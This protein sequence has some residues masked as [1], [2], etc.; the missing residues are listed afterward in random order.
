M[1][2]TEIDKT[3][4]HSE[5]L[6]NI[7]AAQAALSS[8]AFD[9]CELKHSDFSECVFQQ[10]QFIECTFLDCNFSLAKF[11]DCKFVDCTFLRCKLI[12]V[13]WTRVAWSQYVFQSPINLEQC[14]LNDASFFGLNLNEMMIKDCK[15]HDVDFQEASLVEA[16]FSGSDCLNSLFKQTN[17]SQA[18]FTD[19]INY[20]INVFDNRVKG[21]KFSRHEAINLLRHLD[22]ELVD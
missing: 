18:N 3:Q 8:V 7:N 13:D 14:I 12:G 17:L 21:A 2:Q 4:Y 5:H 11:N 15:L 1:S 9:D 16:D 10:C 6:N 20:N 22:I 19:A